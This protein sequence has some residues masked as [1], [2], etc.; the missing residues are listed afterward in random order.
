MRCYRLI[1]AKY[2]PLSAQGANL[3]GGRFNSPGRPMLYLAASESV[4]ILESR[5]HNRRLD[6]LERTLYIIEVPDSL[7]ARPEDIGIYLPDDWHKVPAPTSA[8]RFGDQWFESKASLGLIVPSVP[9]GA[10]GNLLVNTLHPEFLKQVKP[11]GGRSYRYDR[12][13]YRRKPGER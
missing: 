4:A 11:V 7:V 9:G 1:L 8:R 10:D 5:V 2:D 6:F 3:F 12:R 13:L